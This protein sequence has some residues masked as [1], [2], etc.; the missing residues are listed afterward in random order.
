MH[1]ESKENRMSCTV[2]VLVCA[3]PLGWLEGTA[4]PPLHRTA[5]IQVDLTDTK[6]LW[7]DLY[8]VWG[9]LSPIGTADSALELAI[10]A[11][12]DLEDKFGNGWKMQN[13]L[14][15]LSEGHPPPVSLS[16]LYVIALLLELSCTDRPV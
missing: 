12:T 1:D 15:S 3:K 9:L 11:A 6:V 8:G 16:C 10:P 5:Q 2:N 13:K 14:L 4:R 7:G